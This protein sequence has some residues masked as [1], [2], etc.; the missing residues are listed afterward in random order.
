MSRST[1]FTAGRRPAVRA[2]VALTVSVALSQHQSRHP[3]RSRPP[4]PLSQG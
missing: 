2:A 3:L 1:R 4:R